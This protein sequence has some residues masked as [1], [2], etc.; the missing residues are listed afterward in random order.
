LEPHSQ[1]KQPQVLDF[2]CATLGH[3]VSE[4]VDLVLD[5]VQRNKNIFIEMVC[6]L[7]MKVSVEFLI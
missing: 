6:Q 3:A 7:E 4:V 5:L 2:R 1:E